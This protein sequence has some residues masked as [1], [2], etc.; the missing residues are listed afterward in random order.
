MFFDILF[1]LCFIIYVYIKF[2]HF[3]YDK[4]SFHKKYNTTNLIPDII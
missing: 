4:K 3:N 1:E 2:R